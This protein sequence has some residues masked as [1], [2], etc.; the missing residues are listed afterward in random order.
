MYQHTNVE[1]FRTHLPSGRSKVTSTFDP[2]LRCA[3]CQPPS[4]STL[5]VFFS[6]AFSLFGLFF[7]ACS[8]VAVVW[9]LA[10][11]VVIAHADF[12]TACAVVCRVSSWRAGM[13]V[14]LCLRVAD[15]WGSTVHPCSRAVRVLQ[16]ERGSLPRDSRRPTASGR[17][18]G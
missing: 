18:P 12:E 13:F 17:R 4:F 3:T 5:L 6:L 11:R 9:V 14:L 8:S 15:A 7:C 2:L 16:R 1:A 10:F